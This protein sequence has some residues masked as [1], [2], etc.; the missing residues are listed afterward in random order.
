MVRTGSVGGA[1]SFGSATTTH[2]A[3]L[4]RGHNQAKLT[5]QNYQTFLD[6]TYMIP[7]V[8]RFYHRVLTYFLGRWN[9]CWIC[10]S[11]EPLVS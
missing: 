7:K 10:T 3:A 9:Q 1:G 5:Q 2:S 11:S 8:V 6:K 4:G